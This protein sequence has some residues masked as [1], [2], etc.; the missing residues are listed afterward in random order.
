M[1]F[2]SVLPFSLI[3]RHHLPT[4]L[5]SRPTR[6]CF[7]PTLHTCF[8]IDPC[9]PCGGASHGHQRVSYTR[10]VH[11]R[12]EC[13][14]YRVTSTATVNHIIRVIRTSSKICDPNSSL[15]NSARYPNIGM[16][17]PHVRHPRNSDTHFSLIGLIHCTPFSEGYYSSESS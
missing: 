4:H 7:H 14:P 2:S 15:C 6:G 11:K 17:P 8:D 12:R 16:M 9:G 13:R 5:C 3:L 10:R 1:A